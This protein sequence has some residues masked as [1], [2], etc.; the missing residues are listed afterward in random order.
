VGFI[1]HSGIQTQDGLRFVPADFCTFLLDFLSISSLFYE[2]ALRFYGSLQVVVTLSIP[3]GADLFDG[4]PEDR[5]R[6]GGAHLFD[7]PLNHIMQNVRTEV[8]VSL[9]PPLAGRIEECLEIALT[10]IARPHGSVLAAGFR[11]V[12]KTTIDGAISRLVL[13]RKA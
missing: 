4:I 5:H 13:A 11:D 7:P 3:G 12:V 2:R 10:E 8:D 1:S 6:L 9:H